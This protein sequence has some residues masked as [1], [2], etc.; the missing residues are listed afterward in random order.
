MNND[1]VKPIMCLNRDR[2]ISSIDP[3]ELKRSIKSDN[4]KYYLFPVGIEETQFLV[5]KPSQILYKISSVDISLVLSAT[6]LRNGIPHVA[7][8]G[9][10]KSIHCNDIVEFYNTMHSFSKMSVF[11]II[12]NSKSEN[13]YADKSFFTISA[14]EMKVKYLNGKEDKFKLKNKDRERVIHLCDN[15]AP[16]LN[17]LLMA[18]DDFF[19]IG[20]NYNTH[21]LIPSETMPTIYIDVENSL[22]QSEKDV[23]KKDKRLFKVLPYDKIDPFRHNYGY[24]KSFNMTM[25]GSIAFI[26]P[27]DY[28]LLK[29]YCCDYS[30]ERGRFIFTTYCEMTHPDIWPYEERVN[31]ENIYLDSNNFYCHDQVEYKLLTMSDILESLHMMIYMIQSYKTMES[32]MEMTDDI[33]QYMVE[34]LLVIKHTKDNAG[35]KQFR[36]NITDKEIDDRTDGMYNDFFKELRAF[37]ETYC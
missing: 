10:P 22:W 31:S 20:D 12:S 11:N 3:I 18:I 26:P 4:V 30:F 17:A 27:E 36:F 32:I 2:T 16:M 24:I 13:D 23:E 1:H 35:L 34:I 25:N 5:F 6:S 7:C 9:H 14:F 37:I 33:R 29:Q 28:A 15:A 19:E 8:N 21:R